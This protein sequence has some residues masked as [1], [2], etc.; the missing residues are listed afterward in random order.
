MLGRDNPSWDLY[1]STSMVIKE[2][3]LAD[4][5]V[6]GLRNLQGDLNSACIPVAF[7]LKGLFV[8]HTNAVSACWDLHWRARAR[9]KSCSKNSF[10]TFNWHP[11]FFFSLISLQRSPFISNLLQKSKK[12]EQSFIYLCK[13]IWFTKTKTLQV[14]S[15][16]KCISTCLSIMYW[17]HCM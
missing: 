3:R 16:P 11:F 7:H 15:L 9:S 5:N 14:K 2:R 17:I 12:L 1:H 6:I 4:R 8:I 10:H 13:I